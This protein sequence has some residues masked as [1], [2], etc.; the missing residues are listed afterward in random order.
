MGIFTR[1]KDIAAADTHRLLDLVEDPVSM[2]KHYIRQLE[3]Q[4]DQARLAL[5]KQFAAEQQ[6]DLLVARTGQMI[7]KRARQAELAVERKEEDIARLAIQEKLSHSKLQQTYL[8]QREAIRKQTQA[9]R[10]E[11]GRLM[12]LHK[13]LSD[14]LTFL[15]ARSQAAVALRATAATTS[16][17][18]VSKISRGF[19]RMEQK[20]MT[21]ESGVLAYRSTD[22]R[23]ASPT[24]WSEQ[25][26]VETELAKLKAAKENQ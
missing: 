16:P 26:E 17:A 15:L 6:Y 18:D 5:E 7:D 22:T 13:E 1:I 20:I 2:A 23:N 14:K 12:D 21:L 10:E 3:E 24:G 8:E 25:D 11:I 19:D 4:I 9:L